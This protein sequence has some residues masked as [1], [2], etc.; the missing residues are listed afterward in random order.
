[1]SFNKRYIDE[2]LL[3]SA[4]TKY[5]ISEI[6]TIMRADVIL[7]GDKYSHEFNKLYNV[8]RKDKDEQ[9]IIVYL[10][11]TRIIS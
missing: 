6:H 7:A 3:Q 2:A 5:G 4:Y 9:N 1:M 8:Y 10:D 11:G